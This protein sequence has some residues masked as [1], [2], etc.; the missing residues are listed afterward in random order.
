[1]ILEIFLY[2]FIKVSGPRKFNLNLLHIVKLLKMVFLVWIYVLHQVIIIQV[3]VIINFNFYYQFFFSILK[4][5]LTIVVYGNQL[6]DFMITS[7][8]F[9][10]FF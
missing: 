9:H 4:F 10:L 7:F 5:I 8:F 6:E 3:Q 1:M 2:I